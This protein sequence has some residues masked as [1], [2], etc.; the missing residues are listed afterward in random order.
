MYSKNG[1]KF[2][3]D[4]SSVVMQTSDW[5]AGLIGERAAP[6]VN[7][8]AKDGEYPVFNLDTSNLL[9]RQKDIQ[10]AP[11]SSYARGDLAYARDTYST[12]EYGFELPL[13]YT[14]QRD[15]ARI[16]YLMSEKSAA[17]LLGEMP[18][19]ALAARLSDMLRRIRKQG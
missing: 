1:T 6:I 12:Q 11:T 15:A 19:K 5:E 8:D 10:R 2:R 13:D 16:L 18:D 14:Q 4:L 3:A 7:V 17:R 9:K